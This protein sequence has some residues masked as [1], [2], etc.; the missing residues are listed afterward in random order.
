M[1]IWLKTENNSNF[2][3][4]FESKN[5]KKYLFNTIK[6]F[7]MLFTDQLFLENQVSKI[8]L[9]KPY[10]IYFTL[11]KVK[12]HKKNFEKKNLRPGYWIFFCFSDSLDLI[13]GKIKKKKKKFRE[14]LRKI[15]E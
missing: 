10:L 1:Q 4:Y 5:F 8:F 3:R 14:S 6:F 13:S 2:V 15:L 11:N 12:L 9:L 7:P